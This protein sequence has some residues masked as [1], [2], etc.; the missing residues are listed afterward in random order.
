VATGARATRVRSAFVVLQVALSLVLLVGAGLFLRTVQQAYA[1]DLGYQVDRILVAE[2]NPGESYSPEAGQALYVE[3]LG[4]LNALP[5]VV[6]A[7]AARVT[8]LSGSA[9]T[10]PV[11]VDGQPMRQDRSNVIPARAN[12][13]SQG[14]LQAMGIPVI[15][16]R[17]FQASDVQ[18]ST[19]VAIVSR[20]L[21]DR[22][23]PNA[24][25][26]GQSVVSMSRLEVVGVV[27]DTVY[28]SA[29]ERDPRPVFY[30]PLAQSYESGVT[31]H[32]RTAGDPL[33]ILPAVRQIVRDLDPRLALTRPRRLVDEFDRS[34]TSA[35]TMATF[36]GL[37]SGIAL[38]LAAVGLYGV[39]AYATR[40]RTAEVG[41][42]LALGATPAS[43]SRMI[44]MRG[45]RL[46]A[47][48]GVL[49][50]AGAFAGMR[51]VRNQL[52]GVEP[53]DPITWLAVFA[54][55]L[56]IGLLACAIPARRAMRID[57]AAALRSS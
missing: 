35:R 7:G 15:R 3:L 51:Y 38:L 4:R 6:A 43:I 48:G 10:L 12:V 34:M 28:L 11:S 5:G 31:L 56:A 27:P 26:I 8:V 47:G 57:P 17:G 9:R 41:L 13:V 16:G 54:L 52:F 42:R 19:P 50:F 53:T 21:A 33:A 44:V 32:V 2:I 24:D 46:M 1:V 18:T 39:I 20:S 30:L 55:L 29:T 25:P 36:V 14:Y 40:Q 37:L 45:A 49:G 23:W 22:L